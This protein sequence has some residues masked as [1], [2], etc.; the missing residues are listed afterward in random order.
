M[1]ACWMAHAER[2]RQRDP[3]SYPQAAGL[4]ATYHAAAVA[5]M[6]NE[7][8]WNRLAAGLDVPLPLERRSDE[9]R[10]RWS[11]S[12]G[13]ALFRINLRPPWSACCASAAPTRDGVDALLHAGR[14]RT[15]DAG[16]ASSRQCA[17]GAWRVATTGIAIGMGR[18][19]SRRPARE[20]RGGWLP[21]AAADRASARGRA[22]VGRC[23]EGVHPRRL[24]RRP[25]HPLPGW[26]ANRQAPPSRRWPPLSI[27]ISR[28]E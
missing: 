5:L 10:K 4:I 18:P 7:T 23:A 6:L 17:T 1:G 11:A 24:S 28:H 21:L 8:E 19:E 20:A 22:A 3:D 15:L 16:E 14:K 27:T 12:P 13:K 25:S 26:P 2:R 9:G